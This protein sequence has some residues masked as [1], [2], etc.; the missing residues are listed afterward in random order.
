MPTQTFNWTQEQVLWAPVLKKQIMEA[1]FCHTISPVG[2]MSP[3]LLATMAS[4]MP[5]KEWATVKHFLSNLLFWI[6]I[7]PLGENCT[8]ESVSSGSMI[9]HMMRNSRSTDK[10]IVALSG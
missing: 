10:K 8:K 2:S 7:A 9:K 5:V 1:L 4:C 6:S 3:I